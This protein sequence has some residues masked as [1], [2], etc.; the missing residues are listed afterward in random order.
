MNVSFD[1]FVCSPSNFVNKLNSYSPLCQL[2]FPLLDHQLFQ[3]PLLHAYKF[4]NAPQNYYYWLSWR[5]H[6]KHVLFPHGPSYNHFSLPTSLIHLNPLTK[7][8]FRDN[9]C[10]LF[11]I[12]HYCRMPS[13]FKYPNCS[14]WNEGRHFPIFL[15]KIFSAHLVLFASYKQNRIFYF[16]QRFIK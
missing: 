4:L 11:G 14:I 7:N 6:I 10:S 2:I 8:K 16:C 3:N 12:C 9:F 13:M 1:S 15:F 5:N